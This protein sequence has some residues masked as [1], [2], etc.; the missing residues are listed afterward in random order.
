MPKRK[1][2]LIQLLR[3]YIKLFERDSKAYTKHIIYVIVI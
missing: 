3:F 2:D 1:S